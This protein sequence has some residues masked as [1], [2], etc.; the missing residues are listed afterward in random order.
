MTALLLPTQAI[1][2]SRKGDVIAVTKYRF[3]DQYGWSAIDALPV[4][5]LLRGYAADL[6]DVT[7]IRLPA[8]DS[9]GMERTPPNPALSEKLKNGIQS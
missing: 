3:L 4:W 8:L 7:P 9:N 5:G 6:D 1:G 2:R